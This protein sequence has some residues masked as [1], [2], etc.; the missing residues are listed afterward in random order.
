MV[1]EEPKIGIAGGAGPY[2]GIDLAR[3]ILEETV[4]EKDQDY[5]PTVQISTP[6]QIED[7]TRF[8][9]GE[10]TVNP[11]HA[12]FRNIMD[13]EFLGATVV[14]LP[15]NTAH[16]ERIW[17]VLNHNL[18]KG[19]CRARLLDMIAETADFLNQECPEVRT[20]GILSTI[21]T[22]RAA[23]YPALLEPKGYKVVVLKEEQQQQIHDEA[24]FHPRHGIKVQAHPVT[25]KAREVLM[26]GVRSL[27]SLGA[28][29]VVLGC[30]EIP[31]GIPEY[32]L[33]KT[34][35]VNPG[36]ILAR[37]LIRDFRTQSLKPWNWNPNNS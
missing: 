23:F 2:A 3:M 30:T 22:W 1:R 34:Y 35:I 18:E 7:R 37:A 16:A 14:G 33:G 29:G 13:L 26:Q 19:G 32:R 8:L 25:E 31:L 10:E 5:L 20:V 4:A 21:G 28:E 11:A 15:C 36:R 27:E 9:L 6:E 17:S 24:L 12:L